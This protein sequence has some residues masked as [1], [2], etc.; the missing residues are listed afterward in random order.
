MRRQCD[1]IWILDLGG[2]GRGTR[3]SENVFDI[4]TPVAIAVAFRTRESKTDA[5]ARVQYTRV[6]GTRQEKLA[7]LDEINAFSTVEWQECPDSWHAPFRPGGK[8]SYFGW[9]LLQ[10]LMPW[11]TLGR[12]VSSEL[13]RL[14]Q[15]KRRWSVV[16]AACCKLE[17]VRK[18]FERHAIG[19]S[20][21]H[22]LLFSIV[23]SRKR[24]SLSCPTTLQF[25]ALNVTPI[26]RSTA[27]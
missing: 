23:G 24:P 13:G 4:Q 3:R 20:A 2:E 14:H 1:K 25:R 17:I 6:E 12:A 5:P 10:D 27:I 9:P 11:Q 15:T 19:R 26:V 21:Q 16:G 18:H 22:P 8:G 7:A